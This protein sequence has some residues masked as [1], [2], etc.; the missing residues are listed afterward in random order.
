MFNLF[1]T[2]HY[3]IHTSGTVHNNLGPDCLAGLSLQTTNP[4]IA[5]CLSESPN[6][7]WYWVAQVWGQGIPPP[8]P[9]RA[10]DIAAFGTTLNFFRYEAV[11]AEHRTH[12]L[13]DAKRM[14]YVL[15][16]G[17]GLEN[18]AT[19]MLFCLNLTLTLML[20][21]CKKSFSSMKEKKKKQEWQN[22]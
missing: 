3:R 17:P 20:Y 12:H 7:A 14:R 18:L 4:L 13:P 10:S 11:L 19:H 8:Q 6:C 1:K 2:L 5:K 21:I 16:H 22:S 15:C 9:Y